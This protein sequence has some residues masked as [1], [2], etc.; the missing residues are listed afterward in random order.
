L[1]LRVTDVER[2]KKKVRKM[3]ASRVLAGDCCDVGLD[4]APLDGCQAQIAAGYGAI[5]KVPIPRDRDRLIWLLDGYVEIHGSDDQVTCVRQGETTV[6]KRNTA[7]RLVFPQLS[8]YLTIETG[9]G[10]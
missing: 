1:Q 2:L 10:I 6:L 7:Y 5:S 9:E 8:L 4:L 3:A